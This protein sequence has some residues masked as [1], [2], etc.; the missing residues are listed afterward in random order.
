MVRKTGPISSSGDVNVDYDSIS[1]FENV[2][3]GSGHDYIE[4]SGTEFGPG[5]GTMGQ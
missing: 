3:L 2:K 5:V 4:G 1:G